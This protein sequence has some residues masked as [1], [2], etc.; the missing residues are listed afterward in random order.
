MTLVNTIKDLCAKR[1]IALSALERDLE[2]G[3]GT[4]R[5]WDKTS[6]SAEKLQKVAD[7]FH[8]TTDYLLGRE[9]LDQLTIKDEKDIEKRMEEIK[10]DLKDSQGLMFSG[11]PMSEEAVDSLLDAMEYIVRQTKV[12]NK[13]YIPKKHRKDN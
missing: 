2:F 11:E 4:I 6:P 10:H 1:K 5:R 12:I 3:N 13:K 7:Y 8:V 9:Q